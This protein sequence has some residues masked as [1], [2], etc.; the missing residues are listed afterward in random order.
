MQ[1]LA[2]YLPVHA[3]DDALGEYYGSGAGGGGGGAG[4]GGGGGSRGE[5]DGDED[6]AMDKDAPRLGWSEAEDA[7]LHALLKEH[8]LKKWALISSSLN[9]L[10]L[11]PGAKRTG[12]QCRARWINHLD[13][14]ILKVA[15]DEKEE[16]IVCEAQARL[17]N[18]T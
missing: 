11:P 9:G 8:G 14:K 4:L 16:A 6:D 18:R 5:M 15:W 1:P 7:A 3:G 2:S 17:G 13:P 12:K 10:N